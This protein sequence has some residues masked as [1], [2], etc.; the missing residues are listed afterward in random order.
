M[1][2]PLIERIES[3]LP[4]VTS[5]RHDLHAHPEP[6]FKEYTTSSKIREILSRLEGIELL[7]A[8]IET[9]V[10]A[11]L[12]GDREG[13]CIAFRADMD[14][15]P[16]EEQTEVEYKST[17]PGVMHACGH[18]GHSAILVGTALV[19]SQMA[20]SLPGK[21]K[22]IFQPAE[23][24]GG[25][26]RLMCERGVL[27]SPKVDA[28]FALHAWS[29]GRVETI[30]VCKGPA[31]AAN[32]P[33]T[34]TVRGHGG[35][36]AYPH[37][38]IDPIVIAAHIITALQTIVSRTVNPLDA[39]VVSIGHI[40][41]GSACNV[42]PNECSMKGTLRYM[43]PETGAQLCESVRQIAENTAKA[44][45]AEAEV[46]IGEGYPTLSNDPKLAYLVADTARDL[47]GQEHMDI[48]ESPSMGVEDFA[49]YA[50]HVPATV[51]RLGIKPDD[52]DSYPNLH[53]PHFDF[54]DAA[55]PVGIRMFCEIAQRFLSQHA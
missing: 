7:P 50:Q 35:H 19:L 46:H 54:N 41:G 10:V 21:V 24:D 8:M 55:L 30:A 28:A 25:G 43:R 22:F 5:L 27:E 32:N 29:A 18:D 17:V 40:S 31:T 23:E 12:N 15:L 6:S 37:N 44:H 2:D 39:A 49:F 20:D 38:N 16:I 51:F 11:V 47:F 1:S 9:D 13:P 4:E 45:G 48:G 14:A 34:I 33:V 36:G 3:V 52:A 26:G 42:I 53:S